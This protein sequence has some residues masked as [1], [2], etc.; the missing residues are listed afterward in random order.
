MMRLA[1]AGFPGADSRDER[2]FDKAAVAKVE[3]ERNERREGTSNAELPILNFECW[4]MAGERLGGFS[5]RGGNVERR[6]SNIE[7]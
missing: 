4:D 7:F 5:R 6:T 1:L 2:R 3:V